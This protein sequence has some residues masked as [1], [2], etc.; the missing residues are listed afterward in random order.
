MIV[1]DDSFLYQEYIFCSLLTTKKQ[2]NK[3]LIIITG[4]Q[5]SQNFQRCYYEIK[6]GLPFSCCGKRNKQ[7]P[8][9]Q[10]MPKI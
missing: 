9:T 10:Y 1:L 5:F 2:E 4:E 7:L 8:P 3:E 6:L